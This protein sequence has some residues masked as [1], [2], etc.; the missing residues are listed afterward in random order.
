MSRS[1]GNTL[2]AALQ[3]L[4][5]GEDL[6]A[7]EGLTFLLLT[8]DPEGWSH[9][10]ML[11]VGEL[12]S[13]TASDPRTLRGALWPNSTATGNL[14]RTGKATLALVH[15]GAGYYLHLAA[16]RDEDLTL[17]SGMIRARFTFQIEDVQEDRVAY[18]ELT[19]GISYRLPDPGSVL[20]R[21]QETVNILKQQPAR[22][23]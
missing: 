3:P 11:S 13:P 5:S 10:A 18:A 6:A 14:M 7:R 20:P 16:T 21:W 15:D 23:S 8:V 1:V 17:S 4:F 2:P 12:V 19:S 9:M 22:A